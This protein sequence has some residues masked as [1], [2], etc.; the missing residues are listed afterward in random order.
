M[1]GIEEIRKRLSD[2]N[3]VKVSEKSGLTYAVVYHLFTNGENV[4]HETVARLSDYI[5]N[6][7]KYI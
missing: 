3:L 5:E 1:L 2:R 6:P 7:E 4:K